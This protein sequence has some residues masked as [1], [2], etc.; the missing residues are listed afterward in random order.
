[1]SSGLLSI[2]CNSLVKFNHQ[3]HLVNTCPTGRKSFVCLCPWPPDSEESSRSDPRVVTMASYVKDHW[4][5]AIL[6]VLGKAGWPYKIYVMQFSIK[7]SNVSIFYNLF[8]FLEFNPAVP[9][10][11][12][13]ALCRIGSG[14][15]N[16]PACLS[17]I[18]SCCN[19]LLSRANYSCQSCFVWL[20]ALK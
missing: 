19:N 6:G 2:L 13:W 10:T 16:K 12:F 18:A 1:M 4:P 9:K 14:E 7:G 3:N 15:K 17:L 5:I 8:I 20:K 11:W